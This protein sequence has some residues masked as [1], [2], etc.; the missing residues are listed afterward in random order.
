MQSLVK[1]FQEDHE[2]TSL[3]E[4]EAFEAFAGFC[5]LS[6]FYGSGF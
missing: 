3:K 5:V 4:D 1:R 2:L 6:S